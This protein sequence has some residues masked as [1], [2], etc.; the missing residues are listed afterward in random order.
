MTEWRLLADEHRKASENM[1]I[2]ESM[3]RHRF[4]TGVNTL[5]FFGWE[6]SAISI[7]YFQG[8]EQEVD[9]DACRKRGIDVV[10][11][12]TGGG[13]VYHDTKG[14]VTYSIVMPV[15]DPLVN[16]LDILGSYEVLCAGLVDGLARLGIKAEFEPVND[17]TANGRKISGNAQTRRAGCILQHGTVLVDVD[18]DLMFTLLKVPDEKIRDKMIAAVK[19]RVTSIGREAG[20]VERADVVEALKEGFAS[21][22]DAELVPTGLTEAEMSAVPGIEAERFGNPEW[23]GRR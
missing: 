17:I 9:T 18:L 3:L 15:D 11:R 23:T 13:A 4:E 14:E 10:R 21:T 22:L 16:D 8:L 1:A 12:I 2:D 20:E 6:P 19:D 7:G 5:R